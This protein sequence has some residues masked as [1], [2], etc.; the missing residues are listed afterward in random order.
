M[1]VH[2]VYDDNVLVFDCGYLI[3]LVTQLAHKNDM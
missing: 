3:I 1:E 2:N